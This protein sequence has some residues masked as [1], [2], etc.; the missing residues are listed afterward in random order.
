MMNEESLIS[1][2]ELNK[3]FGHMSPEENLSN[4][5]FFGRELSIEEKATVELALRREVFNNRKKVN[6]KIMERIWEE[7]WNENLTEFEN[8][9]KLFKSVTPKFLKYEEIIRF[10]GRFVKTSMNDFH[11]QWREIFFHGLYEKFLKNTKS[12]HEFGCGAGYNLFLFEKFGFEGELFGYELSKNAVKL[13]NVAAKKFDK[14]IKGQGFDMRVPRSTDIKK[15]VNSTVLTV[16]SIEQLGDNF[17]TFFDFIF[18]L[19][20]EQFVHVEPIFEFYDPDSLFDFYAISHHIK[21]G[22]P[23]RYFSHLLEKQEQGRLKI[24]LQG[25]A[26]FGARHIDGYSYIIWQKL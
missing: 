17:D 9:G 14:R 11:L 12:L 24:R 10:N 15:F 25:K 16:G 21:R 4:N 20:A 8:T 23:T 3:S 1:S 19:D 5:Q 2:Q 26:G 22:Y 6:N 7:G 13:L 18:R